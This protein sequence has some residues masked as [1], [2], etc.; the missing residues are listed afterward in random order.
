MKRIVC[1]AMLATGLPLAAHAVEYSRVL[2]E[3]SRV[4]FHYTQMGVSM[5]GGFG[6]FS[7]TLSFDPERP[8]AARATVEV[9]LSSIDTG[10]AESDE[11]SAGK[12]WFD[13][14]S[15]PT[16]RFESSSVKAVGDNRYEAAGTLTIKGQSRDVLVPVTYTPQGESAVFDGSFTIRRGDFSIGEGPWASFDVVANDVRIDFR[17]TAAP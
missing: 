1:A 7:S 6:R 14:K 12:Q 16:A 5:D 2:P 8:E 10:L 15:F 13:T 17:I 4:G 9:D 11:E 3:Q